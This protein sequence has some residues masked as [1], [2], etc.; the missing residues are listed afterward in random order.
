MSNT[1][2]RIWDEDNEVFDYIDLSEPLENSISKL[3][4]YG[5]YFYDN[6]LKDNPQFIQQFTGLVD[7]TGKEIYEGDVIAYSDYSDAYYLIE[8]NDSSAG[9]FPRLLKSIGMTYG[10]V[11]KSEIAKNRVVG[12]VFETP[13]LAKEQND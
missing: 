4:E 11:W 3:N 5:D 9:W 1:K 10:T 6:Y 2:F 13:E 12:N 7:K 8:W